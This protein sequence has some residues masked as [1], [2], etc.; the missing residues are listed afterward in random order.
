M[1]SEA[2]LQLRLMEGM[3]LTLALAPE[4]LEQVRAHTQLHACVC[5]FGSNRLHIMG[6]QEM[7]SYRITHVIAYLVTPNKI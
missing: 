3:Q 6:L 7:P 1:T 4:R 5:A 2:L